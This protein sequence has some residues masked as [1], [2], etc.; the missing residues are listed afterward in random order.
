V[1]AQQDQ[2]QLARRGP[3]I[4]YLPVDGSEKLVR[5]FIRGRRRLADE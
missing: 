4:D 3:T 2:R 1:P 5:L